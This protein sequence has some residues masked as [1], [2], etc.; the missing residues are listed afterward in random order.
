MKKPNRHIWC[1]I[2]PTF[3]LCGKLEKDAKRCCAS[4]GYSA[5]C[6][7]CISLVVKPQFGSVGRAIFSP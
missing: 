3:H 6:K 1:E 7:K 5:T 4:R 2:P